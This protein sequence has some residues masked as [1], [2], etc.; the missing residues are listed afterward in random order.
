MQGERRTQLIASSARRCPFPTP[1]QS[2]RL[3]GRMSDGRS[4]TR[5][6]FPG[7]SLRLN[8]TGRSIIVENSISRGCVPELVFSSHFRRDEACFPA[9]RLNGEGQGTTSGGVSTRHPHFSPAGERSRLLHSVH[10]RVSHHKLLSHQ[11][12]TLHLCTAART[13]TIAVSASITFVIHTFQEPRQ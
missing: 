4:S 13:A 12:S 2:G 7:P 6:G 8:I 3:S 1:A 9:C 10:S 11:V 5:L